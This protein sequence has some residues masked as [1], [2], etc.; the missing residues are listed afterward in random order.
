MGFRS[1]EMKIM[2]DE[3][4]N[5][6][7]PVIQHFAA[8]PKPFKYVWK[9]NSGCCG[10]P[11]KLGITLALDKYAAFGGSDDERLSSKLDEQL[12]LVENSH[13]STIFV[14]CNSL[15]VDD[16]KGKALRAHRLEDYLRG[17]FTRKK[18]KHDFML[19]P[20]AVMAKR[21]VFE[22]ENF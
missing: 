9:E 15:T 21:E 1:L 14:D 8:K 17:G 6:N 7:R 3:F 20:G 11:K 22:K 5:N 18:L 16:L 2:N 19:T 10:L 13:G 12:L 4:N